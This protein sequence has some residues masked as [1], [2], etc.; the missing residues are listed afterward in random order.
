MDIKFNTYWDD[1]SYKEKTAIVPAHYARKL[2][3]SWKGS[4]LDG[5][6]INHYYDKDEKQL[7]FHM[8]TD[9]GCAH[10]CCGDQ[11]MARLMIRKVFNDLYAVN[12][13]AGYNY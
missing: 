4:V 7:N 6:R 5:T 8:R 13:V 3:S 12:I 9:C 2:I 11:Y 1:N 10:D